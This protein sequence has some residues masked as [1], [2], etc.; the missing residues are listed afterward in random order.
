MILF[1][2]T[3]TL[4]IWCP[5]LALLLSGVEVPHAT[6]SA[7]SRV[8]SQPFAERWP[9]SP[10]DLIPQDASND[11]L[12]YLV[13]KFVQHAAEESRSALTTYYD[14]AI[15]ENAAVLDL[16]S[17][18]T[19]HFPP[20]QFERCAVLG[21][22]PLEL[23][24]NPSKTEWTVR[25]LNRDPKLPYDDNE[26]DV[27][28]NSLSVDYLTKPLDVFREVSRVLKPGGLAAMAFTNRM[29]PTKVVP[30]WLAPYTED[31]HARI[32]ANYF[33]FAG[34]FE[35][36]SVADVSPPGWVGLRNPMIVVAARAAAP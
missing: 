31:S 33:H 23:L 15:P 19:S 24:A 9:Y 3:T 16:C 25:N 4:I 5:G 21:L 10:D 18:W 11:Q 34:G 27:V 17:S 22:N 20:K 35:D 28:T 12:F 29:F 30:V 32:V 13:P 6:Q 26:F 1:L 2:L 8:L 36:I 14:C 7:A